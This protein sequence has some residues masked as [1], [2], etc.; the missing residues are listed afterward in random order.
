MLIKI[1]CEIDDFCKLFEKQFNT[2]L[3]AGGKGQRNRSCSLLASEVMTICVYFHESGFRTFKDY[4]EKHVLIHMQNDFHGLV[5]YNRFIELRQKIVL[6][7][8]AFV[9][10][11]SMGKCT[12]VSFIDSFALDVCHIRRASSHKVFKGLAQKGKTST[13]WFYGLKLHTVI[14][15]LGEI[16][17]FSI[18]PGNIS[19]CNKHIILSLTKKLYGKLFGDKGYI[20][21][22]H[23]FEKL[24]LNG[25]RVITKL[26]KNMKNKLMLPEDAYL[27]KKRGIIESVG[28]LLKAHLLLEHSRHRSVWGFLL[29]IF[30]TLA[31]YKFR[32]KKPLIKHYTNILPVIC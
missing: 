31:A 8:L 29:H 16:I 24:Y 13:G 26:R 6:P 28:N 21:N 2:R 32:E 1:F 19:D 12:G 5:S 3:L 27:L 22:Q 25:V 15:H 9:Q 17:A 14:N 20:I 4:Y 7:L 10:L 30:S 18:T 11:K 23:L